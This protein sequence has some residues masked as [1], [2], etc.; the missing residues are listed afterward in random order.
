MVRQSIAIS[1]LSLRRREHLRLLLG[2]L[3]RNE[4]VDD[5]TIFLVQD[6]AIN[7]VSGK[8]CASEKEIWGC[9]EVF[10][11]SSLPSKR[12]VMLPHNE[13]MGCA[14]YVGYSV[15]FDQGFDFVMVLANDMMAGKYYVK[16]LQTLADQFREDEKAGTV[17]TYPAE[18]Q[19]WSERIPFEN[20]VSY[21]FRA[22]PGI[23]VDQGAWR[24]CWD[25]CKDDII[26]WRDITARYDY[27][28]LLDSSGGRSGPDLYRAAMEEIRVAGGRVPWGEVWMENAAAK[29]GCAGIHTLS[30]RMMHMGGN[31][32]SYDT[33]EEEIAQRLVS[34]DTAMFN[35]G[36]TDLGN[37][38]K[39]ELV[40]DE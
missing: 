4:G 33:P 20:K 13:G 29:I 10:A 30:P 2:S 36:M 5:A 14:V 22:R 31:Y 24:W 1:I 19:R 40:G 18:S 6:G 23:G 11:G 21:G 39:Y 32:S 34:L 38:D 9:V 25:R 15:P 8:R 26:R 37:V 28:D 17:Q 12:L 3:E 7:P 35:V 16:T 27:Q